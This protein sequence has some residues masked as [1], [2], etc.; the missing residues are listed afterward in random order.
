[1]NPPNIVAFIIRHL[2]RSA[3]ELSSDKAERLK[4]ARQLA[5]EHRKVRAQT[6]LAG[7]PG[8]FHFDLLTQR[9]L[10]RAVIAMVIAAGLS[11]WHA[12]RYISQTA[13]LDSAILTDDLPIDVLTDKGF[14]QWLQASGEQ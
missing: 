11:F 13:D 3:T 1:M 14:D 2:D 8:S 5:L 7:V 12:D 9:A 6:R 4:A 10:A